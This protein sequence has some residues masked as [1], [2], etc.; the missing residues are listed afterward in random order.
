MFPSLLQFSQT[1]ELT[2]GL[3]EQIQ[4]DFFNQQH[5]HINDLPQESLM[6]VLAY[7]K[8]Y[9]R[10]VLESRIDDYLHTF[11]VESVSFMVTQSAPI[12]DNKL[13]PGN[14]LSKVK[15]SSKRTY[16]IH[17]VYL[18]KP[19]LGIGK[20]NAS[21]FLVS[22]AENQQ[23]FLNNNKVEVFPVDLSGLA[24]WGYQKIS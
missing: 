14:S 22:R 23:A 5:T 3:Y 10:Q 2:E 8:R 1:V 12:I 17:V 21:Q 4:A 20:V 11:E 15:P 18:F 24:I 19:V 7:A 16:F 13:Q 9:E 6:Q